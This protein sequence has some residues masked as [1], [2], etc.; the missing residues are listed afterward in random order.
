MSFSTAIIKD[1]RIELRMTFETA[2]NI[3]SLCEARLRENDQHV[4][5][6]PDLPMEMPA[7]TRQGYESVI[8]AVESTLD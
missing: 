1:D 4:I 6:H 7:S 8:E 2:F 5:D 3:R